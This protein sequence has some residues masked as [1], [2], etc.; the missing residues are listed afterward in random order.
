MKKYYSDNDGAIYPN[1]PMMIID[2]VNNDLHQ[3]RDLKLFYKE[4][5]GEKLLS[6]IKTSDK[7]KTYYLI[8][9]IDLRCLIFFKTI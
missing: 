5:V 7:M 4:Y 6:P 2:I 3:K 9:I 8:Q 1:D